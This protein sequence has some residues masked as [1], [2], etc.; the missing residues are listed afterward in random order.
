MALAARLT[1][2]D[3]EIVCALHE[4]RV[5]TVWQLRELF[6]DGIERARKRLA[7]LHDLGVVDRFRPH[8]ERGS[9]PCHYVLGRHGAMIVAAVQDVPIKEVR[10]DPVRQLGLQRSQQLAHLVGVNGFTTSLAHALRTRMP[11]VGLEWMGQRACGLEYQDLVRPDSRLRLTLRHSDLLTAWLEW[12]RATETH[13]RLRGKLRRYRDLA[14]LHAHPVTVLFVVPSDRREHHVLD[15]L[16]SPPEDVQVLVT[17][18]ER[19]HSDPLA[20]NWQEPG[21]AWRATLPD[22]ITIQPRTR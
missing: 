10:F 20:R 13:K 4:H 8:R 1:D 19:H 3:R 5:L 11:D 14:Y 16:N 17:T 6:F 22:S 21:A 2:R 18:A 7:V 9:H 15:S 12:D